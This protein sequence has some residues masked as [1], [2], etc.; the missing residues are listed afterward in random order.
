MSPESAIT[1]STVT[2]LAHLARIDLTP[3]EVQSL[4]S[5]LGAIVD[6]VATVSKVVTPDI[7]PTSHPLEI[8]GAPRVDSVGKT[9][10]VEQA[11]SGAPEVAD[12]RFKVPA[13]LDEPEIFAKDV[14]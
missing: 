4:T 12:S 6:T 5:E 14:L 11:L 3:E 9:F 10:T 13:I 1:P 7:P 8:G 2:H